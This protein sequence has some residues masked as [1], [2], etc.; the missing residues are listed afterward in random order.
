MTA[1]FVWNIPTKT[2]DLEY[3]A[4]VGTHYLAAICGMDAIWWEQGEKPPASVKDYDVLIVSLFAGMQHV[5]TIKAMNP[6]AYVIALPD[7]YFD[8]V[9]ANYSTSDMMFLTQLQWADAIGYVSESNRQF[10]GAI[11]H[12]KPTVKIPMPIGHSLF[13]ELLRK[14]EKDEFIITCDHGTVEGARAIDYSMPNVTAVAQIQRA[15]GLDVVYI[16][17]A[18]KTREY[19][20]FAG[21]EAEFH[22][23]LPF[24]E[25]AIVAARARLGV[26]M[27]ALHGFGRNTLMFAAVGTPAVGSS[28]TD[29]G[30]RTQCDPWQPETTVL[31]AHSLLGDHYEAIREV[32]AQRVEI[33]Y[34][35]DACRK[36]MTA[37]LEQVAQWQ[38]ASN[39]TTAR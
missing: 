31:L 36:Q 28:Y 5:T 1:A 21:L 18:P 32:T 14:Q 7:S 12:N 34:S 8:D 9:F 17:A 30:E 29:F 4:Y 16:N 39:S 20:K 13:F 23:Y 24:R 22:G 38:A 26:D 25:F 37:V 6:N 19:A 27:Y 2:G 10:Y 33:H 3:G 35:F 11:F 15:T